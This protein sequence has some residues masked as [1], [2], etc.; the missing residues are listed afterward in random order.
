MIS[1]ARLHIRLAHTDDSTALLAFELENRGHFEQWI[2]SRGAAFYTPENVRESLR[3]AQWQAQAQQELHYLAWNGDEIVGRITLR[4][5]EKKDYFRATLGY[6]FSARHGGQGY[7]TEA[8]NAVVQ[9]AFA[10]L[11]L[12]RI[13]AMVIADNHSS[14][15]IMRKCSFTQFGHAHSAL[16]RNGKWM[17]ML[18]FERHAN[19][20]KDLAADAASA[21]C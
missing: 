11:G 6:R 21:D 17:D 9:H 2:A 16:L 14:L 20:P 10:T 4:G 8:V 19:H 7:A 18:Y 15:A 1:S 5:I 3:Q 13:E 12:W